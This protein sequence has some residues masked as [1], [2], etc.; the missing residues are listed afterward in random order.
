MRSTLGCSPAYKPLMFADRLLGSLLLYI[1]NT[2]VFTFAPHWQWSLWVTLTHNTGNQSELTGVDSSLEK[3][4]GSDNWEGPRRRRKKISTIY[5]DL[6]SVWHLSWQGKF[7]KGNWSQVCKQ[8]R[9]VCQKG[10]EQFPLLSSIS[11][12]QL[13]IC[14]I[15]T[16]AI[17]KR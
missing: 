17:N 8:M 1:A 11:F 5:T 14:H 4:R 3:K 6:K 15:Q 16:Q 12:K 7:A 9:A 13:L 10:W 2:P